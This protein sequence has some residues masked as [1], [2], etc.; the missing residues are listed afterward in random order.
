MSET[1]TLDEVRMYR[2]SVLGTGL[3]RMWRGWWVLLP[4][5]LVN[6]VLQS[7]LVWLNPMPYLTFGFVALS[8]TSLLLLLLAWCI[9]A[10]AMLQATTGM[11]EMHVILKVIRTRWAPFL[12][13][14]LALLAALVLGFSLAVVPGLLITAL[15]PFLLLAVVDGQSNPLATNFRVI[16][17]RWGRW[18]ITII[19][20][21]FGGLVLWLLSSLDGFFVTGALGALAGWIVLGLAASWYTAAWAVVY[22]SVC[23][24]QP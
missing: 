23:P 15:F 19:F 7:V 20:M 1:E 22:R 16:A 8:V 6:A 13:W 21:G 24:R 18:L 4:I 10:S 17:V 5:I 11:V 12:G 14:S 2:I 9:V 3:V